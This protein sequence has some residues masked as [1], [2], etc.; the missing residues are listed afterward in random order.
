M[1]L[2]RTI[3]A[4]SAAGLLALAACGG[5]QE[6]GGGGTGGTDLSRSGAAGQGMDASR[7]NGPVTIKGAQRGG[8]I[9]VLSALGANT[10]DPTESYYSNTLSILSNLVTRSLTQ[11]VYD[12]K[13]KDMVLIPD[14]ATDLGRPNADYTKWTFTIRDGVQWEN[15]DPVTA[16][17]VAYGIERSFDR[18]TFP[19]GPAY[20]NDYFLDGD[21]YKGPYK[22]GDGYKGVT[23]KGN[24]LTI[25]MAKP[26]PDMPYWGA[27]PAMGPIPK[28]HDDPAKYRQHP[29]STGPYE[30]AA[31]TPEKSLTLVRNPHWDPKTDPGRTAYPDRYV[32]DFQM[33]S[34]KID[35]VLLQDDGDAQTTLTFDNIQAQDYRTFLGRAHDRVVQ[36]TQP[37]TFYWAPDYR[38][39]TDKRVREALAYAY[40]Y[41]DAYLAAGYIQGVT[42]VPGSNL[43]PPGI[44]GRTEYH[45]LGVAPG[46][47]DLGRARRL[48]AAA[49]A[50][51]TEIR[52]LYATDDPASVRAKDVVQKSL[53]AA[54][55]KT[56]PV[57]ST[58]ADSSTVRANPNAPINVRSGGWCSDWPSGGSWFPPL[59]QTTNLHEEGLGSNYAVFSEKDV[60]K[61]IADVLTMPIDRQPGAWNQLDA[62]VARRYFPEFVTGYGGVAMAR[63]SR[64]MGFANDSA[65]GMPTWK[66]LWVRP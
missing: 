61:R 28:G 9:R 33:P 22:S 44:P 55:F 14:L 38:K 5:S 29:W 3:A 50:Q 41:R 66:D 58:V 10:M 39:I 25:K 48:L 16:Q 63:G 40:P 49:H 23:V 64:V 47:T 32:F 54:G 12:P 6:G 2:R 36:G 30:F 53:D 60:D 27:F 51:G 11:Y 59:Y 43:M 62:Y 26:F 42:R 18:A 56:S 31:Y 7:V 15:G 20:S 13:T 4:A 37:C 46:T 17:D 65:Y 24:T 45:P 8:T 1:L 35:A 21:S 52:W 19:E 34:T 57:A